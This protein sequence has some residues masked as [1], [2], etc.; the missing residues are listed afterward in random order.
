MLKKDTAFTTRCR[1]IFS[2]DMETAIV[3]G[4]DLDLVELWSKKVVS[5]GLNIVDDEYA[6]YQH[7]PSGETAFGR[8][9]I[10][11]KKL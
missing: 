8:K 10:F 11:S 4:F 5:L 9:I 1:A 6:L 2:D 7:T 3:F